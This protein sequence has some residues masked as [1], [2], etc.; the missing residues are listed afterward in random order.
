MMRRRSSSRCSRKLMPV[1]SS[2]ARF[3]AVSTTGLGI[4]ARGKRGW[5]RF[6]LRAFAG[7]WA[8]Y[9][10]GD[11]FGVAAAYDV[12]SGRDRRLPRFLRREDLRGLGLLLRALLQLDVHH[13][14][15]ELVLEL[16]AGPLEL[17]HVLA[18]LARQAGQLLGPD[19]H[20]GQQED[21]DH[22]WHAEIHGS[23]INQWIVVSG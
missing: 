15:F 16:V 9:R 18:E 11:V 13:L 10:C 12:W 8:G 2:E 22:L 23:I 7:G 4:A 21:E 1:I 5:Q 6:R 14:G 20:Q 17:R 3:W 19:Q